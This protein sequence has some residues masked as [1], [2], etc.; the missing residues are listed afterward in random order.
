LVTAWKARDLSEQRS[1]FVLVEALVLKVREGGRV[2]A[3]SALVAV[4]VHALGYREILGLHLGACRVRA[5]LE[6]LVHLA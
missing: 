6:E 4:G 3:V 5:H 2:R 1:P